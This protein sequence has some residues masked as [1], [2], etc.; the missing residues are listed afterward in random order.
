VTT[1]SSKL[2]A[3]QKKASGK[4]QWAVAAAASELLAEEDSL[5]ARINLVVSMHEVGLL[6]NSMALYWTAWRDGAMAGDWTQRCVDRLQQTDHDYWALA[7]LLGLPMGEVQSV[8]ARCAFQLATTRYAES[9]KEGR[10]HIATFCANRFDRTL[11]QVIEVGWNDGEEVIE[12]SRWRAVILD[13]QAEVDGSLAG[14]GFGSYYMRAALPYGCWRIHEDTF[15]IKADW[16]VPR[17]K[18]VL[19]DYP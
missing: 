13:E 3:L 12:A 2:R 16:I 5:D 17:S 11:S 4:G 15:E 14:K 6:K 7:A 1:I 9:F 19:R 18:T 10:W 8:L